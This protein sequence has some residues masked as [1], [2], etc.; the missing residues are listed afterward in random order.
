MANVYLLCYICLHSSN[1]ELGK[2]PTILSCVLHTDVN[3]KVLY[4]TT[5]SYT[6]I[7]TR[8]NGIA[9]S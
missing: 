4:P 2:G 3:H 1:L 7:E 5:K 6:Y 9:I 8:V